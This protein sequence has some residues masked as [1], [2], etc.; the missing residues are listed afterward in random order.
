MARRLNLAKD[1]Q[2]PDISGIITMNIS[3]PDSLMSFLDEQ[4]RLRGYGTSSEYVRELIR[5]EQDRQRLRSLL[6]K[7]AASASGPTAD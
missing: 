5:K 2:Y 4:V 6:I 1:C 7:G 3:L